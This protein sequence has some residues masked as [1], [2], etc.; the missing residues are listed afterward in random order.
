MNPSS[1]ACAR[2]ARRQKSWLWSKY[3]KRSKCVTH[4][5]SATFERIEQPRKGPQRPVPF[6]HLPR[7]TNKPRQIGQIL[8]FS[9]AM[10]NTR[11]QPQHL[12]MALQ[13]HPFDLPVKLAEI[14]IHRQSGLARAFPVVDEAVEFEFFFPAD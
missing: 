1:D 13:S 12:D 14:G 11:E 9:I 4:V 6:R 8:R 2:R 10:I 3:S 5:H 7:I